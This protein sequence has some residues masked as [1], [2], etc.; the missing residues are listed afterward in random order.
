[1]EKFTTEEII[2]AFA[3]IDRINIPA[4]SQSSQH[5]P[6]TDC[7]MCEQKHLFLYHHPPPRDSHPKAQQQQQN[8]DDELQFAEQY[9]R[10]F[11]S[12]RVAKIY[13]II[14]VVKF[15]VFNHHQ[16]QASEGANISRV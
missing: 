12:R 2:P 16:Q 7:A 10:E 5:N 14:S 13:K 6:L 8:E 15:P 1:M 11:S 3:V 4:V 9:S